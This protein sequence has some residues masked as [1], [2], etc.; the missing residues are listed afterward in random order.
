MEENKADAEALCSRIHRLQEMIGNSIEDPK[1][2]HTTF[3]KKCV[4]LFCVGLHIL[5]MHM[6]SALDNIIAGLQP[7]WGRSDEPQKFLERCGRFVFAPEHKSRIKDF[8]T[9]IDRALLDYKVPKV[10]MASYLYVAKKE[11]ECRNF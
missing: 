11:E 7:I 6:N 10:Y 5:S 1:N 8:V 4:V 9:S 3:L 2:T